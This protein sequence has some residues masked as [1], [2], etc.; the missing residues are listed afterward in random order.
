[1]TRR[2]FL[3]SA[4][5]FSGNGNPS[6][7]WVDQDGGW[8]DIAA[9][10]MLLRSPDIAV[11]GITI[12]EGIAA[13]KTARQRAEWLLADLHDRQTTIAN[14]FPAGAHV[15]A[16]GPLTRVARLIGAGKSPASIVWMGGAVRVKGNAQGDAEWNAAADARAL[17]AVMATTI[18]L[19]I[20]PLDL[21][22][23]FPSRT[24]QLTRTGTRVVDEIAKAYAEPERFCWDELAAG[25]LVAPGL[26]RVEK[27]RLGANA[28]GKLAISQSGREVNVLTACER[29]GFLNLLQRS[30]RF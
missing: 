19:T 12:T 4:F 15:L 6:S 2:A 24:I 27:L 9:I 1:M 18:P 30:L 11:A 28:A 3:A 13:G 5:A 10:A 22:N 20:C 21:T 16:T 8:E 26:Y 14:D 29:A 23:Q 7:I 17:R 25:Y